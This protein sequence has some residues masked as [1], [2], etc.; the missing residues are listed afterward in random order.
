MNEKTAVDSRHVPGLPRPV[1][2]KRTFA[3]VVKGDAQKL[4]SGQ[5]NDKVLKEVGPKV[6]VGVP[7]IEAEAEMLKKCEDFGACGLK[8][9]SPRVPR[10]RVLIFDVTKECK[11]EE[12]IRNIIQR[13]LREGGG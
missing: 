11:D 13:N 7:S 3:V 5:V 12:L 4:E 10:P 9:E 2:R 8:I 6:S 1:V